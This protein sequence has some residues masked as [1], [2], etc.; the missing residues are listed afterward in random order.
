ML[1]RKLFAL[2]VCLSFFKL[3]AQDSSS[4]QIAKKTYTT[5]RITTSPIIDGILD[6]KIWEAIPEATDFVMAQPGNGSPSR[7]THPTFVLSLIHISEPTRRTP[8]SYA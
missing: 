5:Q 7:D 4:L 2:F 8:I 6:D 3:H 1:P